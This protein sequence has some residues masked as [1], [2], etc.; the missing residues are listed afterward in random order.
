[1]SFLALSYPFEFTVALLDSTN[2][3]LL[4]RNLSAAEI[5]NKAGLAINLGLAEARS[6]VYLPLPSIYR[7]F[8]CCKA[9]VVLVAF[10]LLYVSAA[11][12]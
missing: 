12:M 11:F 5:G 1:M 10:A 7:L 2:D 3:L 9:C 8:Q 4:H 6:A